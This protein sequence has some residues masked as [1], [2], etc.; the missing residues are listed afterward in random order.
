MPEELSL[1]QLESW[2]SLVEDVKGLPADIG[3]SVS[4]SRWELLKACKYR[5]FSESEFKAIL[6]LIRVLLLTNQ[7]LQ[8]HSSQLAM[9][10]DNICGTFSGLDRLINK[11]RDFAEF[12]EELE[13]RD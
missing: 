3:L 11:A 2:N 10:L 6:D 4:T 12:K 5:Q 7:A 1:Q 8:K 13:D 9:K